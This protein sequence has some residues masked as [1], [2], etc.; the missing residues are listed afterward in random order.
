MNEMIMVR[1]GEKM[2]KQIYKMLKNGFPLDI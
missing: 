2:E 1:H